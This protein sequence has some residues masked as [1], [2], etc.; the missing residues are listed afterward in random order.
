L[1]G[2][3]SVGGGLPPLGMGTGGGL[4]KESTLGSKTRI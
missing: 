1:N 3:S 4:G 2:N